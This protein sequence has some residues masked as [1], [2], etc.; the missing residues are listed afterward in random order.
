MKAGLLAVF[1]G[2]VLAAPVSAETRIGVFGGVNL[3][4]LTGPFHVVTRFEGGV[5]VDAGLRERLSLRLEPM[6]VGKGGDYFC[7]ACSTPLAINKNFRFSY[8][9]LPVLMSLSFGTSSVR[10]YLLAG[11]TVSYMTNAEVSANR[12]DVGIS[13]GGGGNVHAGGALLF[14]EVRYSRGFRN[15]LKDL[16]EFGLKNVGIH[17]TAGVT[18]ALAHR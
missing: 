16:P 5:V 7:E 9:E 3:A 6:L 13:L 11:P 15:T 14:V 10:R 12:T 1:S 17:L 8:V 4:S 2:L 18:F